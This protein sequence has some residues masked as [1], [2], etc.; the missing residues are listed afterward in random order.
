METKRLGVYVH[1]PFCRSKCN[2]CDFY[3][4]PG[5]EKL[6][7]MYEK[8]LRRH[9]REYGEYLEQ[10]DVDTVYFGGGTPSHFGSKRLAALLEELYKRFYITE[11]CEITAEANPESITLAD[12]RRLR[13]AGFNRISI[14]VQSTRDEDLQVLG[15]PHT[16][17]DAKRAVE[18]CRRAGF[19]NVSI[20]LIF[21]LPGQSLYAWQDVLGEALTL[22]PDHVSCYGLKVEPGTPFYQHRASYDFPDDDAQADM[23]L[24]AAGT[25][26]Q[27]GFSHYEISN[28]ARRGCQSRHNLKYWKLEEYL[29]LGPAAHSDLNGKRF[30]MVRDVRRYMD[31]LAAG[32]SVIDEIEDITP[33]VRRTE[34]VMLGLRTNQGISPDY[35]EKHFGVSF[36]KA[37]AYLAVLETGGF[38]R[39][40][41]DR[42][43]LT[44]Q[45]FLVSNTIINEVLE[46]I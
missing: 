43:C 33:V 25:L 15:R 23:Y 44:A 32:R 22:K 35:L 39:R 5:A 28:F 31:D 19:Q 18:D 20:D 17:A 40:F 16:F 4:L 13:R 11:G 10:R 37:A 6:F 30:S 14:G 24:Y 1:I 8:A 45:G 7:D 42:Y 2:Y 3:S 27:E 21:G 29:G 38:V 36:A 41:E 9:M 46:R 26:V 12:M 34:Y